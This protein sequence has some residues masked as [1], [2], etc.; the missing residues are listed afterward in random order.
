MFLL[1]RIKDRTNTSHDPRGEPRRVGR[2]TFL[3]EGEEGVS[4]LMFMGKLG[5]LVFAVLDARHQVVLD[6]H[7]SANVM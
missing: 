5:L 6:P 3:G 2:F 7:S 1:L 4:G